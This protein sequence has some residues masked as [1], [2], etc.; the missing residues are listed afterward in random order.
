MTD[1]H[2][3]PRQHSLN[4][5]MKRKTSSRGGLS[6]PVL[7]TEAPSNSSSKATAT[8]TPTKSVVHLS[9]LKKKQKGH[10]SYLLSS[11]R[12]RVAL[13]LRLA[14]RH[15]WSF[16]KAL[17]VILLVYIIYLLVPV[18]H[19]ASIS[20]DLTIHIPVENVPEGRVPL[21]HIL[22]IL[23]NPRTVKIGN[24]AIIQYAHDIRNLLQFGRDYLSLIYYGK[25]ANSEPENDINM[26]DKQQERHRLFRQRL[27]EMAPWLQKKDN[28]I[29]ETSNSG[30]YP[31]DYPFSLFPNPKPG[32]AVLICA[33]N[34]QIQYLQTLLYTIRTIHKSSDI[35]I[36]ISFRGDDDLSQQH[37]EMLT[38]HFAPIIMLDLSQYFNLDK[39]QLQGWNLRPYGTLM[40]PEREIAM[41]DADVILLRPPEDLFQLQQ[42]QD[43][44]ALFFH[45]RIMTEWLWTP[46]HFLLRLQANPSQR[47]VQALTNDGDMYNEHIIESGIV[48]LDKS[49]RYLGLWAA[50]LLLGRWDVRKFA[51][52]NYVYGDKEFYIAGM[53]MVQQPYSL[54]RFYPGVVGN[55]FTDMQNTDV[56]LEA[57]NNQLNT[58]ETQQL[59]LCGR[60]LHFDD[61]GMPLW[62]NGGYITKEDDFFSKTGISKGG[63]RPFYFIDGGD[64]QSEQGH[65]VQHQLGQ[66]QNWIYNPK[67][68]VNCLFPNARKTRHVPSEDASHGLDAVEYYLEIATKGKI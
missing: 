60:L 3:A 20:R 65:P 32:K 21:P 58:K 63:L 44:G 42:Y 9:R 27:V 40:I 4:F 55:V 15:R 31:Y 14:K 26:S 34:N 8:P 61:S 17:L 50:C 5:S 62:S 49:R 54:S 68:G 28:Q 29:R 46:K 1:H 37:R 59:A 7:S 41:L 12:L 38:R 47:L 52:T 16:G 24:E 51:Q 53:E 18:P 48:L 43:T 45:D 39:A 56:E 64:S 33:G 30:D 11:I 23:D 6:L 10:S 13:L 22:R 66:N 35:P 67:M 25:N 36:Y 57:D 2:Q 19:E